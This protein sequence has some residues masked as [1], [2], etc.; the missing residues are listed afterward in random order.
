VRAPRGPAIHWPVLELLFEPGGGD[1]LSALVRSLAEVCRPTAPDHTLSG[2][3]RLLS[4]PLA[5]ESYLLRRDPAVPY[6]VVVRDRTELDHP[7]SAGAA[8]L[9]T[10]GE[11]ALVTAA[12]DRG[13]RLSP[14]ALRARQVL[15]VPASV[16]SDL[17]RA[18][19]LPDHYVVTSGR[20]AAPTLGARALATAIRVAAVADV[21]GELVV[22]A[23]ALGTP[24]VTDEATA[25]LVGAV[26]GVHVLVAEASSSARVAASL[27]A[28]P[29]RCAALGR[30]G[31][32]LV[33]ERH[34]ADR[35]ARTVAA[36][37]GLPL[38]AD[39]PAAPGLRL[40]DRLAELGTPV[41]HP[42]ELQLADRLA[43][44]G[45]APRTTG[46]WR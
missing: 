42:I 30:A 38:P 39:T 23:M 16:R 5:P 20:P 6:A 44:L 33:E 43:G 10:L 3:A 35:T 36:A 40:G 2:A 24:V 46:A 41:G 22:E 37:L 26:D 28:D 21:C 27:A 7:V 18:H 12:G 25:R 19:R 13:V 15:P 32:Q 34:D 9:V 45:V 29:D 4:S 31:R 8:C 14:F 17:R 1:E 11:D